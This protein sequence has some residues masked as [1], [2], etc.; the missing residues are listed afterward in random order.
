MNLHS[1]RVVNISDLR[2]IAER[3][4]PRAVFD[5]IDGG[6]DGELTLRDNCAAFEEI[7][8]RPRQAVAFSEC[9]MRVQV[10]GEEISLPFLLAPVGYCRMMNP[11]G[12]VAAAR[13]AGGAGTGY[14]LSTFSGYKLED[15]RAATQA[16]AWYQLNLVGGREA[17]QG[18]IER[19]RKAGFSALVITVDT[20]TAG[21][22]ERDPRNGI[23]EF[24]TGNLFAR[25]QFLGEIIKHPGWLK[26]FLHDGGMPKL[27]NIIIPGKGNLPLRD[28]GVSL[29]QSAVTWEDM[30]W[31]R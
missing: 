4:V 12:E 17:A 2:L 22:R 18:A 27:E 9:N 13:A 31:I 10:V 8:F 6:A 24:L 3:R 26:D 28:V 15:V 29:A 14:I 20:N 23:S 30:K 11:G 5:Y 21:M 19:A 16:L 25:I 1:S 7:Y